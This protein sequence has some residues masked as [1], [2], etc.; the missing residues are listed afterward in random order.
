MKVYLLFVYLAFSM[1]LLATCFC[2]LARTTKNNTKRSVRWAFQFLAIFALTCLFS[3][4]WGYE[5]GLLLT[6]G[7]AA[8]FCVQFVTAHYWRH[9]VPRAFA[10]DAS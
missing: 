1:A 6:C 2:R 7:V 4:L 3:P 5:P 10:K 9:G 8:M